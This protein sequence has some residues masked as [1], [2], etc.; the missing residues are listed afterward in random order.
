MNVKFFTTGIILL[1]ALAACKKDKEAASTL[2]QLDI[3]D[4][5]A[6]VVS[7]GSEPQDIPTF[8]R[9]YK[10]TKSALLTKV[11]F[12][13]ENGK[14]MGDHYATEVVYELS[15]TF[16][17]L[18]LS[19]QGSNP[20]DFEN[21]IV[22]IADGTATKISGAFRPML[23]SQGTWTTNYNLKAIQKINGNL[24]IGLGENKAYKINALSSEVR[25]LDN[26]DVSGM[27]EGSFAVDSLGT[28][29][30]GNKI[31][32]ESDSTFTS[33][34][35]ENGNSYA[36]RAYPSG[37]YVVKM[38]QNSILLLRLHQQNSQLIEDTLQS[39]QQTNT[40]WKYKGALAFPDYQQSVIVFDKGAVQVSPSIQKVIPVNKWGMTS[41]AMVDQSKSHAYLSGLDLFSK[42]LLTK[43]NFS[44]GNFGY[45][46]F[47][48]PNRYGIS[49]MNVSWNNSLAF[50]GITYFNQNKEAIVYYPQSGSNEE[51]VNTQSIKVRQIIAIK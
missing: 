21:Y 4:A 6:L 35:M 26:F 38:L 27:W 17:L 1:L 3:S 24:L 51:H 43:V 25:S 20:K 41:I 33:K 48:A 12:I 45:G 46:D 23:P 5:Y 44:D 30:A 28:C 34:T 29:M 18:N 14:D 10:Y 15:E 13:A 37:F 9:L 32:T 11:K 50:S 19:V 8:P 47:Y 31:Y 49:T 22:N 2:G 36:V 42:D 7:D 16:F 40:D 39:F